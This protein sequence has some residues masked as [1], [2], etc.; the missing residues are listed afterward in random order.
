MLCLLPSLVLLFLYSFFHMT[1]RPSH[2]LWSWCQRTHVPLPCDCEQLCPAGTR[3]CDLVSK[4]RLDQ[5]SANSCVLASPTLAWLLVQVELC[6]GVCWWYASS[7]RPDYGVSSTFCP[8]SCHHAFVSFTRL[9]LCMS[10]YSPCFRLV[11][12][13][14]RH[15]HVRQPLAEV[16]GVPL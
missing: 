8:I 3:Q 15:L 16:H 11:L 12:Q 7:C 13:L 5:R 10:R 4:V 9:P 1:S 6:C 14:R 2:V